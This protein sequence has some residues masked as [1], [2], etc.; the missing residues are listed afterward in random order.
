MNN[1]IYIEKEDL[2]E[3]LLNTYNCKKHNIVKLI[4]NNY[5][6]D[7]ELLYHAAVDASTAAKTRLVSK[8]SDKFVARHIHTFGDVIPTE[9]LKTIV[10][11]HPKVLMKYI[12]VWHNTPYYRVIYYNSKDCIKRM[13]KILTDLDLNS[14]VYNTP[15]PEQ[16]FK[17]SFRTKFI[18]F[19]A[20]NN[21][22]NI[23]PCLVISE[24]CNNKLPKSRETE[25]LLNKIQ[26][27]GTDAIRLM[28]VDPE[29]YYI[30]DK[31]KTMPMSFH[32][33]V[34]QLFPNYYDE[35][36]HCMSIL[37]RKGK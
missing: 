23:K 5:S 11:I 19:V 6:N 35:L 32:K 13:A 7:D 27:T 28:K 22:D 4:E 21:I 8:M 24:I 36:A 34:K 15:I 37:V 2:K 9:R 33:K 1:K 25:T 3:I 14:I 31:N 30:A 17:I 18:E 26:L 29:Y 10:S 16:L 20:N 12:Q